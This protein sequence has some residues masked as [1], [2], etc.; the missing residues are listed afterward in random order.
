M[1]NIDLNNNSSF[2]N[3]FNISDDNYK[4]KWSFN[5]SIKRYNKF[6]IFVLISLL[7]IIGFLIA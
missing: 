7:F 5:S 1:K 6:D 4:Y 2:N 3:Y